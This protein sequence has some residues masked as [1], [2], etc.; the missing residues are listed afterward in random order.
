MDERVCQGYIYSIR[1]GE[2]DTVL[3]NLMHVFANLQGDEAPSREQM[4]CLR[5]AW[6]ERQNELQKFHPPTWINR[7]SRTIRRGKVSARG[8]RSVRLRE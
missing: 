8:A 2:F 1:T 5:T 4:K 7:L 3:S 6:L